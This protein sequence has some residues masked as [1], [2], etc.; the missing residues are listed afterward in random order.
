VP[1]VL[2]APGE[3]QRLA[4]TCE[5]TRRLKEDSAWCGPDDALHILDLL[6]SAWVARLARRAHVGRLANLIA[7]N[8]R[9]PEVTQRLC[10]RE[11]QEIY[12]VVPIA[13]RI[14]L[15]AALFSYAGSLHV[16]L[17]ADAQRVTDLDKLA[18]AISQSL[19]LLTQSLRLP[20]S[21]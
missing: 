17:H 13:G 2:D 7:T 3:A 12:P 1:L 11:I 16:G 10:G 15:G 20:A 9:G 18:D 8:V 21:S 14:G 19:Q 6:P 5:L 4:V